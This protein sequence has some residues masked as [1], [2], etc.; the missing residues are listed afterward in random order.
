MPGN[1]CINLSY[2]VHLSHQVILSNAPFVRNRIVAMIENVRA[3]VSSP[4]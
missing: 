4:H 3:V 2:I 1:V